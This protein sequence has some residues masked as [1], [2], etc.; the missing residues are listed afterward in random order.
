MLMSKNGLRIGKGERGEVKIG[1]GGGQD[2]F[3]RWG[4]GD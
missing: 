3:F 4:G 1:R 2:I